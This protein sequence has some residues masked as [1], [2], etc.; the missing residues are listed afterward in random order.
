MMM[1]FRHIALFVLLW[2][3]A[4]GWEGN[5]GT[6]QV[7]EEDGRAGL[8][9]EHVDAARPGDSIL[10]AEGRYHGNLLVSK[11]LS[12]IGSR[13]AVLLGNG[14][15]SVVTITAD[16]CELSGFS[17]ENSGIMLAEEDAGIMVQSGRNHIRGNQLSDILFGIYLWGADSNIVSGNT[18]TGKAQLGLGQRGSGIHIYNSVSNRFVGN[19]I[20]DMRDGF[21]ILYANN[22]YIEGC[23]VFNVRYGLHYMYADSNIF[24]GNSFH[25]NIAGA[26]IMYSNG[27]Q[28]FRNEFRDNRGFSS[29]GILFQDCHDL[30]AEYNVITDNT[31]G[32]FMES[33]TGNL[34]RAN[35]IA[36][37]HI[38]LQM[39]QNSTSN[40]FTENDFI[41]NLSPLTIVGK[42]T[43]SIWSVQGRGNYWSSYDGYDLDGDGTG[44]VPMKIQNIFEYL[45][46]QTPGV[47]LYLYSPASQAL[48]VAANSFPILDT[49]GEVDPHPLM[50]PAV[51]DMI[52]T[53]PE[54]AMT[55]GGVEAGWPLF[56]AIGFLI[57]GV[58]Y[59]K[60]SRKQR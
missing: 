16:S 54:N 26:A 13:G 18:V 4:P 17:I 22:S 44:D 30:I 5:A 21:Y 36:R 41:E 47:R 25:D 32:M 11:R 6:V 3:I 51:K 55:D 23:E 49:S 19:R 58:A 60:L 7:T 50:R 57:G 46:G 8:L 15:G 38:A 1:A 53:S 37:N 29:Y 56:P 24:I 45:E 14:T 52:F 42:S 31:V 28:M 10:V 34:F 9:Q 20:S 33:S 12:L 35:L 2:V 39:F 59:Y 27:I 43:G 40:T 48:A